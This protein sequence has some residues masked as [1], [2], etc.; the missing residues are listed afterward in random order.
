MCIAAVLGGVVAPVA[1]RVARGALAGCCCRAQPPCRHVQISHN[2]C[3]GLRLSEVPAVVGS[4]DVLQCSGGVQGHVKDCA[5]HAEM[6]GSCPAA[7]LHTEHTR[8][9]GL[10]CVCLYLR[11]RRSVQGRSPAHCKCLSPL[12][13]SCS[14]TPQAGSNT[15]QRMAKSSRSKATRERCRCTAVGG[16]ETCLG[17][18]QMKM[19]PG[20]LGRSLVPP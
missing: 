16:L 18:R 2:V 4:S 11:G 5:V 15:K 10:H 9:A 8:H 17:Q 14:Q 6:L 1:D 13:S 3:P 7:E 19:A 20:T 12:H